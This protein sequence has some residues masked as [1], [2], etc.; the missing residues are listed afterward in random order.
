M[1]NLLNR[2]QLLNESAPKDSDELINNAHKVWLNKC[3]KHGLFVIDK[4][5]YYLEHATDE[6]AYFI[7]K[8]FADN[9]KPLSDD[10]KCTSV[11]HMFEIIGSD[12]TYL[13]IEMPVEDDNGKK[14]DKPVDIK[15][16]GK[17]LDINMETIS[18][19]YKNNDSMKNIL[20]REQLLNESTAPKT[21]KEQVIELY[22]SGKSQTEIS[23]IT[24]IDFDK[25]VKYTN[26]LGHNV[27]KSIIDDK[28][29]RIG[30]DPQSKQYYD[31]VIYPEK[32]TKL[33][34]KI[35]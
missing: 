27:G 31:R 12:V 29:D 1:K 11:A 24:G 15:S 33:I 2:E 3:K 7:G 25:V 28:D 18:D 32:K 8:K 10:A 21:D 5:D 19:K 17:E 16:F 14:V 22:N 23:D 9:F 35:F 13:Q 20:T 6:Y 26:H 34:K 30:D 4:V